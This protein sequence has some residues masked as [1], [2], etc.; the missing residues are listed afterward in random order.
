MSSFLFDCSSYIL[1]EAYLL[2]FFFPCPACSGRQVSISNHP[3]RI[4]TCNKWNTAF[5]HILRIML[6]LGNSEARRPD[7]ESRTLGLSKIKRTWRPTMAAQQITHNPMAK[8]SNSSNIH[9]FTHSLIHWLIDSFILCI[10]I[11][12]AYESVSC[13]GFGGDSSTLLHS[14][15]F[16]GAWRLGLEILW[17]FLI[18]MSGGCC[19]LSVET[20]AGI[21][22]GNTNTWPFQGACISL[23]PG[24]WVPKGE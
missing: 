9:L 18:Q 15:S 12:L 14:G 3:Y 6:D 2:E 16:G 5:P 7:K 1:M 11:Y 21:V 8:T 22:W 17:S 4:E 13:P 19:W 23:Q 10:S 20:L 24:G